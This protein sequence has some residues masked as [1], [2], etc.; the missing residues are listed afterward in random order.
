MAETNWRSGCA[1][2]IFLSGSQKLDILNRNAQQ[3]LN[4][5]KAT[6][7]GVSFEPEDIASSCSSGA[8][9]GIEGAQC[10]WSQIH[11]LSRDTPVEDAFAIVGPALQ[12][13]SRI[14]QDVMSSTASDYSVSRLGLGLLI[15]GIAALIVFPAVYQDCAQSTYTGGFLAFLVVGYGSMMFA[16]SYVEE[17]QHFWYWICS[18]WI[19]YLHI[20]STR[21]QR[22]HRSAFIWSSI[23]S[24][25]LIVSQRILRR[26]NQTGQKFTAEPD[27]ARN[28]L[29]SHPLCLWAL[30]IL[31]YVDAGRGLF[32]SLPT[33]F[34][35][36]VVLVLPALAFMFKLNFVANDSPEL[37]VDSFLSWMEKSL[38]I[39]PLVSQARL[40]FGGVL[41]CI[42]LAIAM[43]SRSKTAPGK[44]S[45]LLY[46]PR[47]TRREHSD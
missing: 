30:V 33:G 41:C 10:V 38:D 32:L 7:P 19:F 5:V 26:W 3:L 43:S 4:T 9:S 23:A 46:F 34:P 25:G 17:E 47:C 13:F 14:A 1:E 8:V 16:S 28:F 35:R 20:R 2:Y 44:I 37:L 18:G 21:S 27:I 39:V 29:P 42:V 24:L 31:T 36:V 45:T 22:T 40:I 12:Q 15:T 6:F 11:Q